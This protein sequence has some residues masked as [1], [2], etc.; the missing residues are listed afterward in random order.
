VL[1]KVLY[2][3]EHDGFC[4][5]GNLIVIAK[6]DAELTNLVSE[7][8]LLTENYEKVITIKFKGNDVTVYLDHDYKLDLT[9]K[10]YVSNCE[11]SRIVADTLNV[12]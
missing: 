6:D 7:H 9:A 8:M 4:A 2:I 11:K 1:K 3:F 5:Q 12:V 10:I